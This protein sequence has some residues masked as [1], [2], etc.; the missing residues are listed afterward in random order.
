MSRVRSLYCRSLSSFDSIK[1]FITCHLL[2][3]PADTLGKEAKGNR[4]R[5]EKILS[6]SMS[7]I[8]SKNRGIFFF[9]LGMLRILLEYGFISEQGYLRPLKIMK[10]VSCLSH[11]HCVQEKAQAVMGVPDCTC[12]RRTIS[13]LAVLLISTVPIT[14]SKAAERELAIIKTGLQLYCVSMYVRPISHW[15]C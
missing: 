5:S 11:G 6:C 15:S 4:C 12:Y 2:P 3:I 10:L 7:Y 14:L 1:I 8:R 9:K 13:D